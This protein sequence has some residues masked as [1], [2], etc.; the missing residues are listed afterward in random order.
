MLRGTTQATCGIKRRRDLDIE[1]TTI[2]LQRRIIVEV[3]RHLC[4][5]R[6]VEAD[7]DS[8]LK[9]AQALAQVTAFGIFMHKHHR[10]SLYPK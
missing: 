1:L 10:D 6:S 9:R 2:E 5:L 7:T 4:L 3:D 8:N